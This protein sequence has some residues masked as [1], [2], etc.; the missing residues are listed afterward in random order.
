M[1]TDGTTAITTLLCILC[2]DS[3]SN[4]SIL[5]H[6]PK[7]GKSTKHNQLNSLISRYC[8]TRINTPDLP[9]TR[10]KALDDKMIFNSL[11]F[12]V[13]FAVVYVLYLA[14][15]QQWQN[16]LLL[17]ASYLFY[18]WWDWRFLGLIVLST[19]VDY[20]AGLRIVSAS[21]NRTRKAY[22]LASIFTNLGVLG[23]FKYANFFLDELS[24]GMLV[25][26]IDLDTRITSI[27]L[28]VGISF[29]T[30]QT[31]SYT[32]DIYRGNLQ[33]TN[34]FLDFALF[35]AFFPQLVAGPI[36]RAQV[37]LPQLALP[38]RIRKEQFE[39]GCW[40]ILSG[41]YL[42][43]VLADNLAPFV[44]RVFE[45]PNAANGFAVVVGLWAAAFQIYGDFSGYSRIAI[46]IAKIMGIDLMRN[47]NRPYLAIS[48]KDF[49]SRWHISLSTWLR[50]YLYIPLGGNRGATFSTYRNLMLTMVL[51]GLWHGAAWNFV[52]WGTFHGSLLCIW[53]WVATRRS[54][55][56]NSRESAARMPKWLQA[57]LFF[58]VS[59]IGWLLFFVKDLKHLVI[60]FNNCVFS[61]QW[62]GLIGLSTI[63]AFATPVILF[64][65]LGEHSQQEHPVF[66]FPRET[67][68]ATYGIIA[69]SIALF[70]VLE[71]HEFIY[72]QF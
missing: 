52:V 23:L 46:G 57:M 41:Y 27:I 12:V 13:F 28:P 26:G 39:Q 66:A 17:A 61:W 59:C 34:K 69:F 62:N 32:I 68:L 50:D 45:T 7:S 54:D 37:L 22:L 4:K 30:F 44:E 55:Q 63:I 29:Y 21:S 38:R 16:R 11:T 64:E 70:A 49:W 33:P 65:I 20:S 8:W 18:G 35:V 24:H 2:S 72:F 5:R 67:R 14:S 53:R 43:C 58:Q 25:F 1:F 40:L 47:F 31:M 9:R 19:V 10:R 51:G 42:K 15:S 36:E 60:L 71:E 6:N 48:P 56:N 3:Q